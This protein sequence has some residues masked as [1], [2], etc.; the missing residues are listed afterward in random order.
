MLTVARWPI[1]DPQASRLRCELN[2]AAMQDGHTG[3]AIFTVIPTG[4][5]AGVGF[6]RQP[7]V[8]LTA[9]DRVRIEIEGI[10]SLTNPEETA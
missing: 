5:P 7:P 4:T 8:S 9:G 10:G 1:P 3:D 6:M 2:G